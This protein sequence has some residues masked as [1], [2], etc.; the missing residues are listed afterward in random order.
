MFK[1]KM[2]VF[3]KVVAAEKIH[4]TLLTCVEHFDKATMKHTETEE[5]NPLPP[6]EGLFKLCAYL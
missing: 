6:V 2:H 1:Y 3:C 5:K 4:Q